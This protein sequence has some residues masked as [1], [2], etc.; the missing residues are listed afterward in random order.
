MPEDLAE[1]FLVKLPKKG[2]QSECGNLHRNHATLSPRKGTQQNVRETESC[3]R[4]K[5]EGS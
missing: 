5:A 2:D 3:G 4:Q 1:G